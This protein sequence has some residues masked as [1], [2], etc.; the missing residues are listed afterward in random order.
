MSFKVLF[1]AHSPEGDKE[2][3]KSE[4]N[5]GSYHLFSIVVKKQSEAVDV[6]K[7]YYR[8]KN[9]DTIILCPGFTHLDVAEISK[10]LNGNVGITVARGDGPGNR[11]SALA[12]KREGYDSV[13]KSDKPH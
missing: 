13:K 4:I 6:A 8:Q 7:E 5:T 9:I 12:R 3:H 1:I 2:K 10:A 11:I